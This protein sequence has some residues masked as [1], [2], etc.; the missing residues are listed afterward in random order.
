MGTCNQAIIIIRHFNMKTYMFLLVVVLSVAAVQA[1]K[2]KG[3]AK[4]SKVEKAPE[5][6]FCMTD[7]EMMMFCHAGSALGEKVDAAMDTCAEQL[8]GTMGETARALDIVLDMRK[9]GKKPSKG[10][11]KCPTHEE[12]MEMAA[13]EYSGAMCMFTE[14]GWIDS[15]YVSDDALI[16][17]DINS[18]PTEIAEALNSDEYDQCVEEAEAKM[19]KMMKKELGN[20]CLKTYTEEEMAEGAE[21]MNGIAHTEC[22]KG[23]FMK[24]CGLYISNTMAV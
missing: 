10:K 21:V 24:S 13:V 2:G 22:F 11:G 18:L 7:A 3:N 1:K 16:L 23:I 9:K 17:E 4:P 8:N 14:M 19:M 6:G 12:L 20:K 5:S 15:G